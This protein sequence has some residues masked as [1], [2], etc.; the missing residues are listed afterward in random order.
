MIQKE[1][2]YPT[3]RALLIIFAGIASICLFIAIFKQLDLRFFAR[4]GREKESGALI[5]S[6]MLVAALFAFGANYRKSLPFRAWGMIYLCLAMGFGFAGIMLCDGFGWRISG[7]SQARSDFAVEIGILLIFGFI[8]PY[9]V[10]EVT[11]PS[12]AV[13]LQTNLQ[14]S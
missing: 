2:R 8:C 13:L 10:V 3:L 5:G 9:S 4:S 12:W 1:I 7:A 14:D 11:I 6:L